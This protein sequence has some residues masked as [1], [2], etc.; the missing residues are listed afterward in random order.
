MAGRGDEV[1]AG[2]SV[3]RRLGASHVDRERVI[4]V[5]KAAFV[6]WWL[7]RD[8][9]DLW[10]GQALASRTFADLHGDH[11]VIGFSVVVIGAGCRTPASV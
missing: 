3:R 10:V 2:M 1:P 11:T 7:D 4:E 5:L 8:E 6:Q 9:F